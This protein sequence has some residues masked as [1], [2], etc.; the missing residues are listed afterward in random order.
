MAGTEGALNDHAEHP[1]RKHV[2]EDVLQVAVQKH[3]A[4]ELE[5]VEIVGQHEVKPQE[6]GDVESLHFEELLHHE[7][8]DVGQQQIACDGI[9]FWHIYK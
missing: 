2:E 1:E 8:D 7:A 4:D 3:V 5:Q 9:D 6:G